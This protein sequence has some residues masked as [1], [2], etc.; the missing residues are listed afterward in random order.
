MIR[1]GSGVLLAGNVA[2]G[3]YKYY[4]KILY[5]HVYTAMSRVAPIR[6]VYPE[7]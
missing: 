6:S 3:K 5:W 2:I 4:I 1:E 7:D